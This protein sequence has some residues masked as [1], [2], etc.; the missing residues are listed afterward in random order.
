M[1]DTSEIIR[2]LSSE[3]VS[4]QRIRTPGWWGT[5]LVVVLLIYGVISQ[6]CLGLRPDV[7]TQAARPLFILEMLI[8]GLVLLASTAASI[9]IMYPDAYQK[10]FFLSVPYGLYALLVSVMAIQLFLPPYPTMAIQDTHVHGMECALCIAS[11]AL[12]PSALLFAVIRK[13]ASVHL[14]R[15]GFYAVLASSA[16]GCLTL[17]LAEANDG[18]VHLLTWHYIPTLLFAM[19]GAAAGKWLLKW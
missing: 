15:A 19:I 14:L 5:W 17:R 11:L 10:R 4:R 2:Q 3:T 9:L 18:I 6:L 8:L 7:M 12:L 16:M 1:R 13:G